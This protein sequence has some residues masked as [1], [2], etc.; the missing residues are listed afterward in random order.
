VAFD[1][2]TV[3]AAGHTI[4]ENIDLRIPAGSHA[5]I[6]GPSGAGKSSLVGLLLGWH[7]AGEGVVRVDGDELDGSRLQQLRRE[8]AWVDPAVQLW[9]RSLADNLTYGA[10][11]APFPLARAIDAAD[12]RSVLQNLPEGLQTRLGEGGALVSGG[13]G[14]RVRLG[15]A[16][17]RGGI[18]L[19]ILDEPF[20]GLNREQRRELLQRARRLWSDA[21][22]ICITHDVSETRAFPRVVVIE[23]GKVV[24]DGAPGEL[25]AN[26]ASRYRS[27]L[28][29]DRAVREGFFSDPSW[30]HMRLEDGVI[31]E[32][33]K[34][35]K[36]VT[37]AAL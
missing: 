24:E 20:R 1:N 13:E 26:H 14:Q 4:L 35:R 2:V 21:T 5:A 12:L 7:R 17:L 33:L 25:A 29:A 34:D 15:R 27:M 3:R 36:G 16:F 8:T 10:E 23:A 32:D 6:V 30:R 22:L 18:R 37:W 9:N 11:G 28:D 31:E 19:V